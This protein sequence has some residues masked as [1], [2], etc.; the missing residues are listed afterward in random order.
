MDQM[1]EHLLDTVKV[2]FHPHVHVSV[3]LCLGAFSRG[4]GGFSRVRLKER[5]CY[6]LFLQE[7][8]TELIRLSFQCTGEH[9]AK[10]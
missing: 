2:L 1:P 7:L 10:Q 4:G 5:P 3:S 8:M 9:I 6:C